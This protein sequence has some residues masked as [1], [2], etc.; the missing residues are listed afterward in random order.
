MI[1]MLE[2]KKIKYFYFFL[3]FF[4]LLII[5]LL[6]VFLFFGRINLG[7]E[8]KLLNYSIEKQEV[9]F[10]FSITNYDL[11]SK[12]FFYEIYNDKKIRETKISIE[13]NKSLV[14]TESI[15]LTEINTL[16]PIEVRL[17]NLKNNDENSFQS[18][19]FWL[20]NN[21]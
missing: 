1:C 6:F 20:S 21:K 12:D 16:K 11:K 13:P 10:S 19:H 4:L 15:P 2:E 7:A 3:V 17:H 5:A 9:I 14:L 8:L 18:I